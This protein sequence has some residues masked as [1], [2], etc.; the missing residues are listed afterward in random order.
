MSD[1][2]QVKLAVLSSNMEQLN[3]TV[4]RIL[5]ILE[6]K[7]GTPGLLSN[8]QAIRLQLDMLQRSMNSPRCP[9]Y[10]ETHVEHTEPKKETKEP[11]DK[12]VVTWYFMIEK[13]FVPI[14]MAVITA[15]VVSQ[16]VK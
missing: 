3:K 7:N 12:K 10:A 11:D 2:P 1:D 13:V 16:F 15:I 6:S 14:T 9:W 4:D 8:V 5:G